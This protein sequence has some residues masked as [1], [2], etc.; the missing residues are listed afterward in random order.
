MTTKSDATR[1][2]SKAVGTDYAYKISPMPIRIKRSFRGKARKSPELERGTRY[3][4]VAQWG[5]AIEVWR[6]GLDHARDKEAGYLAHNI[7]IGYEV[8]G[9]FDQALTWAETA[10]TRYGNEDSRTYVK[11]IKNRLSFEAQ[12]QKQLGLTKSQDY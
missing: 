5:K 7:A 6:S 8:L 9:D 12:A 3:A 1:Y 11:Q 10:Y 2:L 4:D